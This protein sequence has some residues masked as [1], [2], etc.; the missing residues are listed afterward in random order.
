MP[1]EEEIL[2]SATNILDE[3]DE[4]DNESDREINSLPSTWHSKM[5]ET[6]CVSYVHFSF[7]L[8]FNKDYFQM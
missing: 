6:F 4:C 8:M 1:T 2:Q 5:V 3:N 7:T